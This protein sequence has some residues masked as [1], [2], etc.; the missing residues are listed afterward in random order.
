[1]RKYY[2]YKKWKKRQL[3]KA[4]GS[5]I[6]KNSKAYQVII[7]TWKFVNC[8][9]LLQPCNQI[10]KFVKEEEK[11]DRVTFVIHRLESENI[12]EIYAWLF[13]FM[14]GENEIASRAKRKTSF[15]TNN[16]IFSNINKIHLIAKFS[17]INKVEVQ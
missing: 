3:E 8:P 17:A 16:R 13:T 4:Q 2:K 7:Y 10:L 12:H 6:I 15:P 11:E 5:S 1:M 9:Q 14:K